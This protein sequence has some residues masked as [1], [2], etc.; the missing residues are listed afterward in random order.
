MFYFILANT[1][2]SLTKRSSNVFQAIYSVDGQRIEVTAV[3]LLYN[4]CYDAIFTD[5]TKSAII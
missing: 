3:H 4:I 1:P 2:I 5:N